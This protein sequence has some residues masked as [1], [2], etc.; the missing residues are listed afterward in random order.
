MFGLSKLL[1][2]FY[3]FFLLKADRPVITDIRVQLMRRI[4]GQKTRFLGVSRGAVGLKT[5]L[6][7]VSSGGEVTISDVVFHGPQDPAVEARKIKQL[8]SRYDTDLIIGL[9]S[10]SY[11]VRV[12][13]KHPYPRPS[14]VD[15]QD[16]MRGDQQSRITPPDITLERDEIYI[17]LYH[18]KLRIALFF[19]V[20]VKVLREF[21]SFLRNCGGKV[22]RLQCGG[23][24]V[25]RHLVDTQPD[26]LQA[27][28]VVVVID[29][30]TPL[31]LPISG[32]AW[33]NPSCVY[34]NAFEN[35]AITLLKRLH[36][37]QVRG[38]LTLFNTTEF[39]FHECLAKGMPNVVAGYSSD[40]LQPMEAEQGGLEFRAALHA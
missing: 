28:G 18:P 6:I 11:S 24:A 40:V 2:L 29:Q 26:L 31:I 12:S 13:S 23:F 17:P 15:V 21:D 22:V 3:E 36:A 27:D 25:L 5:A 34:Q 14:D 20:Q 19:T 33:A 30:T 35:T 9:L 4:A 16:F 7:E 1:R 38:T 32:G 37:L 39:K 10:Q 8:I